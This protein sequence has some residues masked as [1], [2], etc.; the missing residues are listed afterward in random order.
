MNGLNVKKRS[1]CI[2]KKL[3]L[4]KTKRHNWEIKSDLIYFVVTER[5]LIVV[6]LFLLKSHW[7]I[8]LEININDVDLRLVLLTAEFDVSVYTLMCICTL[9][10]KRNWNMYFKKVN[11]IFKEQGVSITIMIMGDISMIQ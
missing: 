7:I 2:Y 9:I 8:R 6:L 11:T 3:I 5:P 10:W 1:F 4:R